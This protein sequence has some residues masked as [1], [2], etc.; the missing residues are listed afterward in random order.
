MDSEEQQ[1]LRYYRMDS[2]Y[3]PQ[4]TDED[5]KK[6]EEVYKLYPDSPNSNKK[7]AEAMGCHANHIIY[8]KQIYKKKLRK[9]KKT[10]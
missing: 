8:Y 4:W 7:I 1:K 2:K 3:M 10:K 5:W 9:Q 6:F